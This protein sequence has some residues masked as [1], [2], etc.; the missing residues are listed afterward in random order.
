MDVIGFWSTPFA[1]L[2]LIPPPSE[3][4]VLDQ[5]KKHLPE[6]TQVLEVVAPGCF[7]TN[8]NHGILAD[9]GSM[10]SRV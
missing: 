9:R 1:T 8:H 2:A 3:V 5:T 4:I 7:I 6:A 10:N